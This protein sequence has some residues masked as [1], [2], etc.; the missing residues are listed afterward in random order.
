MIAG[1]LTRWS[2]RSTAGALISGEPSTRRRGAGQWPR[3]GGTSLRLSNCSGDGWSP[4]CEPP[5]GRHARATVW[6]A[7]IPLWLRIRGR[8]GLSEYRSRDRPPMSGSRHGCDANQPIRATRRLALPPL[9]RWTRRRRR[10]RL[11]ARWDLWLS[12]PAARCP[13]WKRVIDCIGPVYFL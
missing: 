9:L 1:I 12:Y 2:S 13:D 4:A 5:R 8:D 3:S 10:A 7:C 6:R 11:I